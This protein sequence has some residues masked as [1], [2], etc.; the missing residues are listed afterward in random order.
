MAE[1]N[2]Q[3]VQTAIRLPPTLL[4]RLDKLAEHMSKG[5]IRITRAEVHRLA[6]ENGVD[7]LEQG[8]KLAKKARR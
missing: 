3:Q 4:Q 2:E 5:G 8:A 7:R 6:V 1:K